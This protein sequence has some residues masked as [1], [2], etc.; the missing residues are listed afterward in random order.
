MEG[1]TRIRWD[2]LGRWAL[3]GVFALV[4]YLY[5]GPALSWI[6]TYREAGRQRAQVAELRAENQRLRERKAALSS[7]GRARARGAPARHGQGGRARL[8]RRRASSS[9]LSILT[10]RVVRER[11]GAVGGRAAPS[12][13]GVPGAGADAR[14]RDAR[15]PR[16][17]CGAASAASFTLDELADLYDEGTGWCTDLAVEIAPDEPFAWDARVVADAAFG[18]YQ[19]AATDFAGGRRHHARACRDERV[20][21]AT[22]SRSPSRS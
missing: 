15:G 13:R 17:S 7:P 14:A 4:L 10:P 9:P 5:I 1:R 12:R 11:P 3:I 16:A 18:R 6:S 22:R 2:R 21:A 19:R 20:A 8:H